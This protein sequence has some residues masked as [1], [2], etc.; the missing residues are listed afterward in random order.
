[1]ERRKAAVGE[2]NAK[3]GWRRL[4]VLSGR[5]K[6]QKLLKA[7]VISVAPAEKESAAETALR[8]LPGLRVV[9]EEGGTAE[10][11]LVKVREALGIRS[12]LL[13]ESEDSSRQRRKDAE[14]QRLSE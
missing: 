9:L 7:D 1:V 13:L 12:A 5:A 11:K 6:N 14:A 10:E 2:E 4:E 3:I 8:L